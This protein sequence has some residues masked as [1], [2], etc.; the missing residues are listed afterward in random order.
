MTNQQIID[1]IKLQLQKGINKEI[2]TKELLDNGWTVQ[3]IEEAF[4]AAKISIPNPV[5][6]QSSFT[7]E[8]VSGPQIKYAGF[9]VRLGACF[10]DFFIVLFFLGIIDFIINATFSDS[11]L[12]SIIILTSNTLIIWG[13]FIFMTHRY[14]AT[15][16]KKVVGIKVFSDKKENLKLSQV[17]L[18]ETIGKILS[19]IILFFGYIMIGF[20]EKKQGLHDKIANTVVMYTNPNKK[21][22][23]WL[24]IVIGLFFIGIPFSLGI[25]MSNKLAKLKN[26]VNITAENQVLNPYVNS[27]YGFSFSYPEDTLF[28]KEE[29]DTNL[30]KLN[31][32]VTVFSKEI[33]IVKI[34]LPFG[35]F[36]IGEQTYE[37]FVG[38]FEKT[39]TLNNISK[40]KI[41][42]NGIVWDTAL[43]IDTDGLPAIKIITTQKDNLNYS[44]LIMY[45]PTEIDG[46]KIIADNTER[47][48][49]DTFKFID[50]EQ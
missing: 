50:T 21:A 37:Q 25:I 26:N 7:S 20:T 19:E 9:W 40:E 49:I 34:K 30:L 41:E 47:M 28:L 1:F 22:P 29:T 14:Q 48:F 18:R 32:Y 11:I 2:I 44:L 15:F 31:S 12:K 24:F 43:I 38:K 33:N 17:I 5:N 46:G 39:E 23:V 27:E 16:G 10:V 4:T 35:G 8:I 42:R 13:Y 45:M 6:S 3:D 36:N